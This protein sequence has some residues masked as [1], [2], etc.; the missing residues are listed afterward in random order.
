MEDCNVTLDNR[1]AAIV[2]G[3]LR[4]VPSV[5]EVR[6]TW[7]SLQITK[8]EVRP[9][10]TSS[11]E[12]CRLAVT[13]SGVRET[14]RMER[15]RRLIQGALV[16]KDIAVRSGSGMLVLGNNQNEREDQRD[17]VGAGGR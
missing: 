12:W 8:I 10:E 13:N 5:S 16:G 4:I 1:Y 2:V 9:V 7:G 6:V 3:V 14:A 11:G 17:I 15:D